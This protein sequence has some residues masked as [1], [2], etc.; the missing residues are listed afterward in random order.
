MESGQLN[1]NFVR[2][3]KSDMLE[4]DNSANLG[5]QFLQSAAY[6]GAEAPLKAM[7]QAAD[8]FSGGK[9]QES[10]QNGFKSIGVEA[11]K[12]T[13]FGTSSWYAQQLGGAVGMMLPFLALR[14][15][16]NAGANRFLPQSLNAPQTLLQA[17]GREAF[18]SGGA[19]LLYG[20][21]LTPSKDENVGSNSFYT[22]RMK[23]GL[24]DMATF[25]A[26]G[27]SGPYM[28]KGFDTAASALEK[29]SFNQLG[30]L[31][32][33]NLVRHP[34]F[35]GIASGVPAGLVSSEVAA[36]K[37]GRLLPTG[38]EVKETI[39]GMA[40]VG[41]VM[42]AATRFTE[43][44]LASEKPKTAP[45]TEAEKVALVEEAIKRLTLGESKGATGP[46]Q[47]LLSRLADSTVPKNQFAAEHG[48]DAKATSK[49]A[50][51]APRDYLNVDKNGLPG[52]DIV[53][54]ASGIEAPAHVGF[55]RAVEERNVPIRTIT[56]ASGGSLVATLY[57]NKYSVEQIK[58]ILLS[59]EFRYPR[60]DIMAKVFHVTD[61]WNLFPYSMDFK[62]WLQEFVDKYNLKPQENLRIV[63]A[64]KVT[65]A[66]VVFEGSN[67]N[68]TDALTAS[69]AATL[70]LNMKPLKFQGREL[71]DGFYYHPI[72]AALTQAPAIVSK[73]GFV[74]KLPSAPLTPWDYFMHLREMSYY[75]TLKARY[76]DPKGHIIAETG[77][78]DL[79]TTTFSVSTETL[80][81]L[82]DH[83]YK[84]TSERL[85]QPDAIKAI[86]DAK[87]PK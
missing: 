69:T 9:M 39:T 30:R 17:A 32:L 26:L 48:L 49:T 27:F 61:P 78:P 41:G 43:K 68:L 81:K 2:L 58:Q 38:Q 63:A 75:D 84:Q 66:P 36:L 53:L 5:L 47:D 20:T 15:V 65:R 1:E 74:S 56:G 29:T 62:P 70:G 10:V 51:N 64:D 37:D 55:L 18:V 33:A 83:A 73:I 35:A 60:A 24:A 31:N 22:D 72:P 44:Q 23:N 45:L 34:V 21:L 8:H 42:A 86:Q 52:L 19:G 57:A 80:N 77:M 25:A 3:S 71:I 85:S 7:A 16:A 79:A 12:Q 87:K 6:A 28:G 11:P 13:E 40:F 14:G 46:Q 54:G 4:R 67:Y 59:N 82:I 50:A 76:P